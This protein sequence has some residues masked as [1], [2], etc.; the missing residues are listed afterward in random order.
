[1]K[2]LPPGNYALSIAHPG[3]ELR[4]HAFLEQAKPWVFIL[5][6]GSYRTGQDMMMDSIK[7]ID[8]AV[9]QD[10]KLKVNALN[11]HDDSWKRI[12]MITQKNMP[13]EKQHITDSMIY[14]ELINQHTDFFKYYINHI[15][16]GLVKRKIKYVITDANEQKNAVHEINRIMTNIAV[17]FIKKHISAEI[18]QY[19]YAVE[20][21]L[22]T[23]ITED[24]IRISLDEQAAERKLNVILKYPFALQ[25]LKQ[26]LSVDN[27]V[28]LEFKKMPNGIEEIKHLLKQLN[29]DF[30][31]NE[32][33]RPYNQVDNTD[34]KLLSETYIE[35]KEKGDFSE[36]ITYMNHIQP[37]KEK[38]ESIFENL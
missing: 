27:N 34:M 38:L 4:L 30:F 23:N 28:I 11:I 6:D 18:I 7:V 14:M 33:L 2:S 22:N 10:K 25:E 3:H 16:N 8:R 15:I 36:A 24:C 37:L 29:P 21:P 5:T 13:A 9:K 32:Y 26:N 12:L 17:N 19:D 20:N 1:M 31:K 35:K